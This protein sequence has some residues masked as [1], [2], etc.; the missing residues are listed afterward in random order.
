M[1]LIAKA[2]RCTA[3]ILAV[4]LVTAALLVG[5]APV[6]AAPAVRD[7]SC[8]V[9]PLDTARVHGYDGGSRASLG[10]PLI[11]VAAQ[12][13]AEGQTERTRPSEIHLR[14][15]AVLVA[16]TSALDEAASATNGVRLNAQLAG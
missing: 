6:G 11:G 14:L 3:V 16:P 12:A 4:L 7:D 5:A 13:S 9:S 15:S 8:A 1:S 10:S 2:G